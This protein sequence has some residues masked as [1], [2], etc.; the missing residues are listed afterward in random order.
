MLRQKAVTDRVN[1]SAKGL[2]ACRGVDELDRE[3]ALLLTP[4]AKAVQSRP[5]RQPCGQ[6]TTKAHLDVNAAT[7]LLHPPVALPGQ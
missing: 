4:Q 3:Q 7:V 2:D 1:N 6:K 5:F